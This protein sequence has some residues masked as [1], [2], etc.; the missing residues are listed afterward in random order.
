MKSVLLALATA[1]VFVLAACGGGASADELKDAFV[2]QGMPEDQAACVAD[3]LA[4]ELSAD[5]LEAIAEGTDS[6]ATEKATSAVLECMGT[7]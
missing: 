3:K 5:E 4:G 7:P 1:P 6:A 2:E